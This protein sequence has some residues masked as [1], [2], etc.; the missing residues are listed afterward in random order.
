LNYSP[1]QY[2]FL[3]QAAQCISTMHFTPW[4]IF[5]FKLDFWLFGLEPAGFYAH[6]LFSIAL[7]GLAGFFFLRLWLGQG[8]AFLG[9][10]FFLLGAPVWFIAQ[11]AC[12]RHYTEGLIFAIL[13]LAG[14]ILAG[15]R[16]H[17]GYAWG[18]S[19]F[20]LLAIS[21]K[22]LYVPL[23]GMLLL[24]PE[25]RLGSRLRHLLPYFI[26]ALVYLPWR[27]YML[28][29]FTD[30][31]QYPS[32]LRASPLE[33]LKIIA[34]IPNLFFA[35]GGLW[36]GGLSL[37]LLLLLIYLIRNRPLDLLFMAG[38]VFLMI[39]PL[40]PVMHILARSDTNDVDIR[41]MFFI[42]WFFVSATVF[43]IAQS[44]H[45]TLILTLLS[46]V[47][48]SIVLRNLQIQEK[49]SPVINPIRAAGSFIWHHKESENLLIPIDD[50]PEPVTNKVS[51]GEIIQ[52]TLSITYKFMAKLK[53]QVSA[54]GLPKVVFSADELDAASLARKTWI[55]D[56]DCECIR[57]FSAFAGTE[58]GK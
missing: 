44:R 4:I 45:K 15:R 43:I 28:G 20:Y 2:F 48:L 53:P 12:F 56:R 6:N 58:T 5:S 14:F 54:D 24:I 46:L 9:A 49:Y 23:A 55:Y 33:T 42:W 25:G 39:L 17:A 21:A 19:I 1:W 34:G 36:A 32:F 18:G 13:A 26:V 50:W 11:I 52:N 38:L 57:P 8:W 29:Q 47:M 31:E 35:G 51:S 27:V 41:L 7:A 40:F 30:A 10:G 16:Q 3:P 22:E 37:L